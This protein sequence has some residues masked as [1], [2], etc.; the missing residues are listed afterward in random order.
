MPPNLS[1]RFNNFSALALPLHI[2]C[3]YFAL[4]SWWP[5]LDSLQY[6][7]I[8]LVLQRANLD[9]V[10]GCALKR[11]KQKGV[12]TSLGL[13]S[14][15]LLI[16]CSVWVVVFATRAHCWLLFNFLSTGTPLS[17]SAK[18]LSVSLSL[19]CCRGFTVP[20]TPLT[21]SSPGGHVS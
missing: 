7:S 21:F 3:S 18:L 10:S 17:I 14:T 13:L 16:H 15:L 1:S 12:M 5:L 4:S 20:D 6:A 2:T 9:T 11:A 19:C 8:F